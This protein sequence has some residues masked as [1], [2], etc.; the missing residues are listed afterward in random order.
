MKKLAQVWVETVIYTL[1]AFIILGAVLAFVKPKI[2]EIQDKA[3]IEQSSALMNDIDKIISSIILSAGNQ[4][5]IEVGVTKGVLKIDGVG[6]K[7]IFELEGRHTYSEPGKNITE[8]NLKIYTEQKGK[9][10]FVTLTREYPS[11]NLRYNNQDKLKSI[12]KSSTSYKLLISNKGLDGDNKQI[13]DISI[14]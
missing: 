2:Q 14:S 1:I 3:I 8:G 4:R 13:I 7:L 9:D 6:D 5:L 12:T 11:Y 10:N